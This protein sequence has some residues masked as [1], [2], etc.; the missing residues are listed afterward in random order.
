MIVTATAFPLSCAPRNEEIADGG[1]TGVIENDGIT[2]VKNGSDV[3]AADWPF[4][5]GPNK[6][7]V[8]SD[9]DWDPAALNGEIRF[10]WIV[11]VGRGFSS[12]AVRGEYLYIIGYQN[13]ENTAYCLNVNS[14]KTVWK[15][16]F[17]CRP[18]TWTGPKASPV[19]DG[20]TVYTFSQEGHLHALDAA[21]GRVIWEKFVPRDF[22]VS[23]PMWGFSSSPV[24]EDGRIFLNAGSSG[25][26]LDKRNGGIVWNSGQGRPGYAAVVLFKDGASAAVFGS[27]NLYAVDSHS[28]RI[29]W[30]FPWITVPAVNGADPLVVG[31]RVFISSD[32]GKGGAL[33]DFT[34]NKPRV[35]WENTDIG[36][37]FSSF[38]HI[39]GYLYG[40]SG[41]ANTRRGQFLCA[42]IDTGEIKWSQDLGLGSLLAA[43]DKL[44]LLNDTGRLSVAEINP[45]TYNEIAS[46]QFP[47]G[48]YWPPPVLTGNRLF[49][50]NNEGDVMCI[51]IE[52]PAQ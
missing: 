37:H 39:D 17:S 29:I 1:R 9:A 3:N 20:E 48:V 4:W 50:R 47:Q 33:I 2:G 16:S 22:N 6:N 43:G 27:R 21:T 10:E 42:D 13:N 45:D 51:N 36:S 12:P 32:Y 8:V 41:N 26:A 23:S 18:G 34:D 40:N 14:G 46:T 28:G 30:S 25:I 38:V 11:N 15:F 35:V 52:H 49:I 24:V 19:I 44:I 7:S 5:R 31:N